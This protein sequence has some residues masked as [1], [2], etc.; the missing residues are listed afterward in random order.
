V[1]FD[2]LDVVVLMADDPAHELKRGDLGT[3]VHAYEE[4]AFEVEFV[5]A[6][7]DTKAVVTLRPDSLRRVNRN[8]LLSVRTLTG[9][10]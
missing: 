9:A 1:S 8:D 10:A 4:D 2:L 7:G 6:A 5:T 3:I